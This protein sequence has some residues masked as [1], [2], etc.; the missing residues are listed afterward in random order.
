M[1]QPPSENLQGAVERVTFHSEES[2][3]CVV[4]IRAKGHRELITLL[5]HLPS[6]S[7]GE[8]IEATGEWVQHP[9]YGS[10][11]RAATLR[12]IPPTTLEGIE[13]YLGSGLIKG[14][15][16]QFAK[17]LVE[18]FGDD[19]LDVIEN[20]P[21]R[22]RKV[23]GIGPTRIGKISQAWREQK[24]V[25]DIMV[26]L[27]S[28]GVST[29]KA[30]RI[31]K[32]YGQN[33][34]ERVKQNPYHLAR[35][36]SGIGFKSAD[37]IARD[38]G[39]PDN[40]IVRAR[41][42][43]QHVLSEQISH[44]H[45]AFPV[46]ELIPKAGE[47]LQID[48]ATLT[49]A[50]RLE[51]GEG[52]LIEERIDERVCVFNKR[53][54]FHEK[55]VALE[56]M[57]IAEGVLPWA[58]LD[59]K[60]AIVWVE[61][62]LRISLAD[63]QREAIEKALSSKVLVITGGPGTGKTTLTRSLVTILA[64]KRVR[65]A[66]CSPTGRAA[67]RLSECTGLQ[68]KTIHRLLEVD[69]ANGGFLRDR[70]NSLEADLII[71][72]EA[73]MVDVTLMHCLLQAIPSQAALLIVGDADQLPSVGPGRV[74]GSLI[75]SGAV[76]VV[77]LTQVFRQAAV[78]RIITNAHRVNEGKMPE[79]TNSDPQS[80]FFFLES[81]NPADILRLVVD[82][83]KRRLPQK[84]GCDPK[85]DIQVLCPMNRGGLGTRSLNTELQKALNPDPSAKVEKFGITFGVGDKVM[86][87]Q[88]DYDKDV[89]N[90]DIGWIT[91]LDTEEQIA[92]VE[93]DDRAVEFAFSE[94]DILALAYSISI[95][96]SQGS[97][98]PIVVIP[99]ATQHAV[100]LKRNLIY[101][102]MTRGKKLVVMV[103]QRK[104]L[105]MAVD[106]RDQGRRWDNLA[107]RLVASP[108]PVSDFQ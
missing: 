66:L 29:L 102:G 19:V 49:E 39:V 2:G 40:S 30:A 63:L 15:G 45:C 46:D 53:L 105:A 60:K 69:G 41:A 16:P 11:F 93:L 26:F 79:V 36:V 42:G 99:L 70:G 86:V 54:L 25:R 92:T 91:K 76:P 68:A 75:K 44:G 85:R 43:L 104:A 37:Q 81:E 96:K 13:R 101:T 72:D 100:M 52:D 10:Q 1:Q 89:F 74:L 77:R 20:D 64:S 94:L 90:G 107:A 65:L 98:Y 71:V 108:R 7:A 6:I 9:E 22:L 28:H 24:V 14:I 38:L 97:E 27:Q 18:T 73:S 4:K 56:F 59:T 47:L 62:S 5:G 23:P 80:D 58:G 48:T 8:H 34:I 78:S 103:G 87:I 31:Y 83:V 88:N 21:R 95:H 50:L 84:Y 55:G 32:T 12:S 51:I 35:D 82:L 67:K 106:S 17:R 33:A 57:R 61:E 3:Y